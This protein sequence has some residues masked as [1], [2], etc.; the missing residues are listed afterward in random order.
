MS[1][2]VQRSLF[3]RV[4]FRLH[5]IAGIGAGLVRAVVGFTGGLLGLEEPMLHVL[6]PQLAVAASN[7]VA[8]TP[9]RW[10]AD[11]RAANPDKTVRNVSWNGAD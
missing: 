8:L 1:I 9:D 2:A 6:N 11:M 7:R 5:W 10:I 4:L 3:K